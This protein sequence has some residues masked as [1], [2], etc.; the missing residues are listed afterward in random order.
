MVT[1]KRHQAFTLVELLVVIGII[2]LLISI[3]LPSLQKARQQANAVKCASNLRQF[4]TG[5]RMWQAENQK[6]PFELGA[7]YGNLAM[8]KIFGDVWVCPQADVDGQAFN[9]VPAYIHGRDGSGAIQ[10]DVALAPGPN[11]VAVRPGGSR[12]GGYGVNDPEAANLDRYEIWLDD[13]PGSGDGDY[14]DIGFEIALTGDGFANVKVLA[15]DAGD[16][17]DLIDA[18]TG[19][20]ALVNAGSGGSSARIV[21]G[22]ASYG[23]NGFKDPGTGKTQSYN[24]LVLKP[25]KVI[26]MDYSLGAMTEVDP[27]TAWWPNGNTNT[28][29]PPR[30]ARHGKKVNV[31]FSDASVQLVPWQEINFKAKL[32]NL[33]L[34]KYYRVLPPQ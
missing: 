24:K 20:V 9:V 16:T 19:T 18:T 31:L 3:L 10:Y 23:I 17:F 21:A 26:A 7:Y 30:F 14:N 33:I 28:N 11:A 22:K 12:P 8:V 1:R 13:R 4:G 29:E 34:N 15:K 25:D 6:K 2:A 27:T 5:A 32:F